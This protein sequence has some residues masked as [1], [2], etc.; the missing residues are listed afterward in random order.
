MDVLMSYLESSFSSYTDKDKATAT[1]IYERTSVFNS[2]PYSYLCHPPL[3]KREW[4]KYKQ[5]NSSGLY[6]QI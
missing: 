6:S 3:N 5:Y 1:Q 4:S 2:D